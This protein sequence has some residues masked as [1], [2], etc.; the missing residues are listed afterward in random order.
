[1][2]RTLLLMLGVAL[3]FNTSCADDNDFGA[4]DVRRD[5]AGEVP[6]PADMVAMEAGK[7]TPVDAGMDT[8]DVSAETGT[9]APVD[10]PADQG[11]VALD[12]PSAD[13]TPDAGPDASDADVTSPA[14]VPDM[15]VE[16]DLASEPTINT[17]CGGDAKLSEI[18]DA[19]CGAVTATCTGG[20]AQFA[21]M[22]D[23]L[24]ACNLPTWSCGEPGDMTGNTVFCRLENV[25]LAGADP[26]A[27][28]G[29]GPNSSVCR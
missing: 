18:C 6:R 16:H 28:A 3:V 2:R 9:D 8:P 22:Q 11:D 5:Q 10:Q 21:T 29:T 7:D 15:M 19:Y 13:T 17:T 4:T 27:C 20:N 1:M 26:T 14:D 23:C 12:G 25:G 24:T